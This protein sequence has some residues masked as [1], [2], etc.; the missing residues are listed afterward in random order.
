[1]VKGQGQATHEEIG[2]AYFLLEYH[3]TEFETSFVKKAFKSRNCSLL[4][5]RILTTLSVVPIL[6]VACLNQIIFLNLS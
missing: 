1:M 5:P 2:S 3:F 6:L 4:Y